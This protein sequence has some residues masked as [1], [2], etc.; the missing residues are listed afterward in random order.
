MKNY[1][2][3]RL[4]GEGGF[5][6]AL[7]CRRKVDGEFFV[8]K[9][10]DL[11]QYEQGKVEDALVEVKN[12]IILTNHPN[13]VAI[14]DCFVESYYLCIVQEFCSGGDLHKKILAQQ[15]RPIPETE[16]MRYFVQ[17]TCA[18]EFMHNHKIMHRDMKCLNI[19]LQKG[20][21]KVGDF[22]I[23]KQLDS[24]NQLCQ[25]II[26]TPAYFPPEFWLQRKYNWKVD[27]W[28]LGCIL[29]ELLT[30][31]RP[32]DSNEH[33]PENI[34]YSQCKPISSFYS[35]N[36]RLLVSKLLEKNPNNRPTASQILNL[37][38]VQPYLIHPTQTNVIPSQSR[39]PPPQQQQN[40]YPPPQQQ[41]RNRSPPPTQTYDD[42]F[43]CLIL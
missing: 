7:L 31:H 30:L 28:G 6:K 22:G 5:G 38:F 1:V 21:V 17:I 29:Y 14:E 13:I 41:Q 2:P 39:N 27:I 32:F 43:C 25:T 9:Q 40:R 3:I 23:S 20:N 34:L 12:L 42:S 8:I 19:F 18:L 4:L 35:E 24:S 16:V 26:G 33:L 10:V 15:G 37:R 36:I 11:R